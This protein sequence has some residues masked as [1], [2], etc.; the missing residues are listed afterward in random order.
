MKVGIVLNR[1]N[2]S[3]I[4]EKIAMRLQQELAALNV[5]AI[6]SETA[7][8]DADIIH[9]MSWAFANTKTPQPSTMFVTHLDDSHK[10]SQVRATLG[11]R[12]VDVGIC[13][14]SDTRQQ[15]LDAGVKPG[16]VTY[17]SPAHDAA[18]TPRRIRLGFTTRLYPDGRKRETLLLDVASRLRLDDFEFEIFGSGWEEVVPKLKTSGAAVVY[19]QETSDYLQDYQSMLAAIPG[20]DYYVYL[21]LDEGSLG[22]LDA[23]SAGV[24]T[25]ITPQ[26]FHLDMPG[27]ITH[28]V[29]SSDDLEQ[30]FRQIVDERNARISSIRDWTWKTYAERHIEIWTAMSKNQPLSPQQDKSP[31]PAVAMVEAMR[32]LR[33]QNMRQNS[34][35]VRRVLSRISHMRVLRPLRRAV[36]KVRLKR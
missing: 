1:A 27:G 5:T 31:A 36:D 20:F 7:A 26:G 23:L 12:T 10:V 18:I 29:L 11:A 32:A 6:I 15:L 4:I 14:S 30:V 22:T 21:G 16:H 28:P 24:K 35:S 19:H 9:H 8:A 25:I 33:E 2:K 13:M 3:W 34:F 17:V